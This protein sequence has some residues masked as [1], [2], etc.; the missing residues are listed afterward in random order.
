MA[1]RP[2]ATIHDV[3]TLARLPVRTVSAALYGRRGLPEGQRE[4]V[5][6]AAAKLAFAVS[7]TDSV[8]H[9]STV[10]IAVPSATA[11]FYAEAAEVAEDVLADRGIASRTV[12]FHRGPQGMAA[13]VSELTA[14]NLLTEHVDGLL[15]MGAELRGPQV[16]ALLASPLAV[17][18]VGSRPAPWATVGIDDEQAAA[19]A[20]EHLLGLDHW[21]LALLA[22]TDATMVARRA[23]FTRALADHDLEADPDLVVATETSIDGGYRAM[24]DLIDHLGRPTAVLA[25]CD[26]I[27]FGALRALD[28]HGLAAPEDVSLIGIDD[29]PM[30]SFLGLTTVAQ[31]V[32]DQAALAATLL[33]DRLHE[34]SADPAPMYRLPTRLVERKTTRRARADRWDRS[35]AAS[36]VS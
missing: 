24:N 14:R 28:E 35:G 9:G 5:L 30:S 34:H 7:E 21:N 12:G 18:G 19:T 36:L 11:W 4:R 13:A 15:L 8:G 16:D 2:A 20:T 17:A 26:E 23:G 32:A 1:D 3:A 31:P 29:H 25:G 33:A 27:A 22:G 6:T 10:A